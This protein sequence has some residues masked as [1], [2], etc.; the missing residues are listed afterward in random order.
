MNAPR[1]ARA[2]LRRLSPSVHRDEIDGDLY[3]WFAATAAS[4]GARSARW[5]YRR[6][7]LLTAWDRVRKTTSVMRHA[8][9]VVTDARIGLRRLRATPGFVTAAVLTIG[10]GL[11]A[12]VLVF[13][14]VNGL[15]LRPLP[16]PDADALVWIFGAPSSSPAERG[17]VTGD[18]G[19]RIAR[20]TDVFA[21]T[22][23]IGDSALI[24]DLGARHLRWRG[25]WA[26]PGLTQT[27]GITPLYGTIPAELSE[28]AG[29]RLMLM[30]YT[31]WVNEFGAN[32]SVV[33]QVVEFA[34]NKRFIIAGVLPRGLEF[35]MVRVPH[36]GHGAGFVAGEQDFWI[37]APERPGA[38]PGGLMVGR[39]AG[40]KT[41]AQATASLR[42]D[43][44][45]VLTMVP[46]REQMIGTLGAVMPQLQLFALC[47]LA[48]AC[49][50][51]ASLMLSRAV[52]AGRESTLRLSL[53]A[54][55][56]DLVRMASVEAGLL[57]AGGLLVTWVVIK[58]GVMWLQALAPR[59]GALVSLVTFDTPVIAALAVA[60][61]MIVAVLGAIPVLGLRR[62]RVR[63]ALRGLVV[64]QLALSVAL[65]AGAG[66]LAMSLHR[67][68]SIDA[69]YDTSDVA[70][71]ET[72]LY[73]PPAEAR[74]G[75]DSVVSRLKALPGVSAVGF[76]HSTPLTG[77]WVIEDEVRLLQGAV[78]GTT[79]KMSGSFVAY[80]YFEAM[81]IGVLAGRTFVPTDYDRRDFPVILNDVAARRYFPH[82]EAVGGRVFVTGREREVVG[83]VHATR[84][85][86]LESEPAP[87]FYQPFLFG[88]SHLVVRMAEAATRLAEIRG[89]IEAAD[90]RFIIQRL[91]PMDALISD[92]VLERRVMARVLTAFGV[93]AIVLAAIGLFGV[94]RFGA[95]NRR[96]EF[97]V[98][99]ALGATRQH[100]CGVVLQQALR[101]A[102]LGI[103]IGSVLSV[104]VMAGLQHLVFGARTL[105]ALFVAGAALVCLAVSL[106]AA[107]YPAWRAAAVD[108]L[109]ALKGE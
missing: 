86:R 54:R 59:H 99:V 51:V 103:A 76:V 9:A 80:D 6:I 96:R 87:Q 84:D 62:T 5:Q 49:A 74:P 55:L 93:V 64:G 56:S 33:G 53:G 81:R 28:G 82:G 37:L 44:D 50:N 107:G 85:V 92:E 24:R 39:L 88:T 91:E 75:L 14:A 101:T 83:V 68:L 52:A 18:E 41:V 32:P 16:F 78:A 15:L 66:V 89:V 72:I 12:N 60:S 23:A 26:T 30:G 11:G 38:H 17:T 58:A 35:P 77:Q 108:P 106:V 57:V 63:N 67:V 98:R 40:G 100:I 105:D 95:L 7:V 109:V 29:P 20:S 73:V 46:I 36:R 104:L 8:R 61:L 69:G 70:V 45:R 31:R 42:A 97:G 71:A 27:L 19:D 79:V 48:V 43:A 1:L 65:V 34:D 4:H 25:I 102:G 2:I 22:A 13:G 47:V 10:L 94:T 3:E 90:S 21:A